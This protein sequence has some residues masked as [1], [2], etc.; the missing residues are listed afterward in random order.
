MFRKDQMIKE[1][2]EANAE[3]HNAIKEAQKA[4]QKEIREI[5]QDGDRR[6]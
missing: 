6:K 1:F 4:L 2:K 3:K 5:K